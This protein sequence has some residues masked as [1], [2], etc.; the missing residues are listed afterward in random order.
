[1][2]DLLQSI[3]AIMI[4][5]AQALLVDAK[6]LQE[7]QQVND[8][9]K[10]QEI[11]QAAYRTDVRPLIAEARMRTGGA[12]QPL[13]LFRSLKVREQLINERGQK[14]IATGL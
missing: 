9:V 1:L 5:Y 7:A 12:L 14:T 8:V 11:L 2:E 6:A 3:E 4:A 10:A 13:Q